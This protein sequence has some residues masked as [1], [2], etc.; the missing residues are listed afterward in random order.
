METTEQ[1]PTETYRIVRQMHAVLY[2]V[3]SMAAREF[4]SVG[5]CQ[6]DY[7]PETND[8]A[9]YRCLALEVTRKGVMSSRDWK[10]GSYYPPNVFIF[11]QNVDDKPSD[12]PHA[13]LL[14]FAKQYGYAEE[15]FRRVLN[16][17]GCDRQ[18][19]PLFQPGLMFT[20]IER[21]P[22]RLEEVAARLKQLYPTADV[23]T[24]EQAV[25]ITGQLLPHEVV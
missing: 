8:G 22:R 14:Q 2:K 24:Y 20:P 10:T 1:S 11:G 7:G 18:G 12:L 9:E 25:E 13:R 21:A 16:P 17:C 5:D 23:W 4:I 15:H 3:Y 6:G 19:V